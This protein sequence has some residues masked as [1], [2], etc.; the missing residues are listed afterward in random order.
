MRSAA[1]AWTAAAI[2]SGPVEGRG[3]V[4]LGAAS[5][6]RAS[7][8]ASSAA[9]PAAARDLQADRVGDAGGQ[10]ARLGRGLVHGD[11]HRHALAH[12]AQSRR[13]R[14]R[15]PRRARARRGAS[16]VDRAHRLLDVPGAVG[17]Q[18]QRHRRAR[19][20][21]APRRPGRRRRR[22]RPSASR[23]RTRRRRA[24]GGRA[25][26]CARS[27][28]AD[29]RVDRH[30][31]RGTIVSDQR[32]D[33]RSRRWPRRSHSAMSTRGQ[34]LREVGDARQRSSRRSPRTSSPSCAAPGV[35]AAARRARASMLTPS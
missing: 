10:R 35:G 7:A 4:G 29:R 8:S 33:R 16:A 22:C 25:D 12:R 14:A 30:A 24:A 5:R 31:R 27:T 2:P 20:Q 11:P 18:P 23:S 34:R 9:D 6:A 17:V 28:R 1:A 19:P 13:C 21:P 15:A 3:E 26:A 32:A